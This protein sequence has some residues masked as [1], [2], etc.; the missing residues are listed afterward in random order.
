MENILKEKKSKQSRN[1]VNRRLGRKKIKLTDEESY[2]IK[3]ER[4]LLM[5]EIW[6]E[7]KSYRALTNTGTWVIKEKV[8]RAQSCQQNIEAL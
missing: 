1:L 3:D 6:I 4:Y 8:L 2:C 7:L 5:T